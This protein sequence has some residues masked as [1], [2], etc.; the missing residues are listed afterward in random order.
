VKRA[1]LVAFGIAFGVACNHATPVTMHPLA[2][3]AYSHY[4]AG[5]LA[6]YRDDWATASTEL[7]EAAAA[8]P[9]QPVFAVELARALDKAKRTNDA[10]AVLA[11]ARETWPDHPAVWLASG[12]LIADSDRAG[13]IAAYQRAIVLQPDDEH[14]YLGLEKLEGTDAIA[15][16][17]TL[18]ALIAHVPGSV[19]GHYHLAQRLRLAGDDAGATSELRLVLERD[20]DQIDA[21]LDLARLLRI[22][23]KLDESI[24]QTRSAFDR[25]GQPLDIAEELF[26]LL[27]E[28]DDKQG[29]IDLLTLL[30]DD[31]S[32][33]EALALVARFDRGLGRLDAARAVTARLAKLDADAGTVAEAELAVASGDPVAGAARALTVPDASPHFAHARRVAAD[34]LLAAGDPAHALAA[35]EPARAAAPADLGLALAAAFAQIDLGHAPS[36]PDV[37]EVFAHVA[38][39]RTADLAVARA[40]VADRAGDRTAALAL[41]EPL[42]ADTPHTEEADAANLAGYLLA[43][44]NLRLADAERYLRRARELSPGDAAVLDSW[45]WL[46]LRRGHARDAVRTL[47][48]AARLAPR[49]PEILVHLAAAWAADGAPRTAARVLDA[50]SDLHPPAAVQARLDA[51][52]GQLAAVLR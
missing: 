12:D 33:A 47:G 51:L 16:E 19:D 43:D 37:Q 17:R 20:P 2:P 8:A 24:A 13:A 9:D 49:E 52:R 23:G 27:C 42:L 21:R 14:A 39:T 18:R 46:Q 25:A 15:A 38:T 22:H 28:A 36:S 50:A 26:W 1:W 29:A 4:L 48:Q 7:A 44:A 41:L 32:D 30:D 3:A 31:R 6:E 5:Q 40:R 35:L 10:L 45:G 11:K 34:A